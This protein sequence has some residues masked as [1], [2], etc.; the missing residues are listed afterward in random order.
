MWARIPPVSPLDFVWWHWDGEHKTVVSEQLQFEDEDIPIVLRRA[1]DRTLRMLATRVNKPTFETHIRTLKPLF[2]SERMSEGRILCDITLGVPSAFTREWVEKRHTPLIQGLLEEVLDREVRL[3]FALLQDQSRT[4]AEQP[5]HPRAITPSLFEAPTNGHFLAPTDALN[6]FEQVSASDEALVAALPEPQGESLTL[7]AEIVVVPSPR[8]PL[9]PP[10]ARPNT[11]AVSRPQSVSTKASTP[12]P[13]A[14]QLNPRYT[15]DAFVTGRSNRLAEGGA[16]AVAQ[17][18]GEVYNPLFL[19]GPPGIGKTHLMHAIGHQVVAQR[20]PEHVCYV[21]GEAFT[22]AFVK[23][24]RENKMEEF[25]RRWRN[26]DVFLL[27]DIQFI[28]GK[29]KTN[30][31]FFHTFNALYQTG[32]QIVISSDRSPRELKMMDERLRSRFESGLI[33]DIAPPDLE[34]RLAIL[35]KKAE[36]ERMR[37]PDDVLLY[38]ARLVQSNIRTLEG[39]LVKLVAYASL[40]NSPVTEE[41]ASD[42]LARYFASA[43]IG[44]LPA[45]PHGPVG[46]LEAAQAVS[47]APRGRITADIIQAVVAR[48]YGLNPELLKGKKRDKETARARQVAMLLMREL[49]ETSLPGIGQFFGGRDHT[50]VMH[51]CTSLRDQLTGDDTLRELLSELSNQ[52]R[53]ESTPPTDPASS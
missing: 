23:A 3:Q 38:M 35:Q 49:T 36:L 9:A 20:G 41:L 37:I 28:A 19:Y 29:D 17:A 1:W 4:S 10:K 43:G 45:D 27:D 31:E 53:Q 26:I 34:T 52:I 2:L 7:E 30:E 15:F 42:I 47:G 48:R 22:T 18:P 11:V 32:K 33:A 51:A 6:R 50:T 21:S 39:A 44:S 8:I 12:H 25:R 14:P 16:H 5:G 24:S 46:L 13:D 40:V